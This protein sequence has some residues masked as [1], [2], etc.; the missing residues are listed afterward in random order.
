MEEQ[1]TR[2]IETGTE[3]VLVGINF[4]ERWQDPKT[5]LWWVL[6]VVAEED[7]QQGI[8]KTAEMLFEKQK[9]METY[10]ADITT[11]LSPLFETDSILSIRKSLSI[12]S[13]AQQALDGS[14]FIDELYADL[15]GARVLVQSYL[16][17]SLSEMLGCIQVDLRLPD[18]TLYKAEENPL[19]IHISTQTGIT[20]GELNWLL[21]ADGKP[22]AE[23]LTRNSTGAMII[24][25]DQMITG[26]HIVSLKLDTDSMGLVIPG[27]LLE[28]I[29]QDVVEVVVSAGKLGYQFSSES[30][31]DT[32]HIAN[33]LNRIYSENLPYTFTKP[34][35]SPY[36]LILEAVVSPG[37]ENDYGLMVIHLYVTCTLERNGK[38]LFF[39]KTPSVKGIGLDVDQALRKAAA[40][41]IELID[42]APEEFTQVIEAFEN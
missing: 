23:S 8:E 18:T 26:S 21:Y 22:V 20:L 24:P 6:A 1:F 36:S 31:I 28:R 32:T 25:V 11:L 38:A 42:Q 7:L 17:S 10:A 16:N 40:E 30:E 19:E 34:G 27:A 15:G 35:D 2:S 12:L 3:T 9:L 37:T 41:I 33:E 29:P 14:G 13:Q 5:Q 4:P 39:S